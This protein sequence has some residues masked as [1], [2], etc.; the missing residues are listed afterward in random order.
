MN[1][2]SGNKKGKIPKKY[3]PKSLSKKDRQKQIKSIRQGTKRPKLK[4]FKSK[5]SSHTQ[6]FKK[7][8]GNKSLSWI[9]QNIISKAG[10][11]QIKKKGIAAFYNQGSRPNQ[12]PASW[13]KARLY[14]VIMGGPAR[15][16]DRK[17]WDKYK[18][19]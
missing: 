12:T 15:K 16:V 14:S 6:N 1:K 13:W 9:Y 2:K 18:K 3:I 4:S 5:P 7:K 19:I 8:Y 17:I 10:V 11:E